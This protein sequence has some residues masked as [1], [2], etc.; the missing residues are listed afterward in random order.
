MFKMRREPEFSLLGQFKM[1]KNI[2]R[3]IDF[4]MEVKLTRGLLL[5]WTVKLICIPSI[6]SSDWNITG[7]QKTF[8]KRMPDCTNTLINVIVIFKHWYL[9][10]LQGHSSNIHRFDQNNWNG[11]I[12]KDLEE[13][14]GRLCKFWRPSVKMWRITSK[15]GYW[16][17]ACEMQTWSCK[18]S[19]QR[20]LLYFFSV[21]NSLF[22]LQFRDDLTFLTL[23]ID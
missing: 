7:A 13:S 12:N 5:T 8:V 3:L 4:C 19:F 17:L 16:N 15:T 18:I 14:I 9:V 6:Y 21:V 11:N 20:S 22:Q 1:V 23:T 2:L 10:F